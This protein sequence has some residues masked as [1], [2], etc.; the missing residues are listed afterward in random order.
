MPTYEF[1]PSCTC[2]PAPIHLMLA[3]AERDD[4]QVCPSC[5]A[6]YE[7]V[8]FPQDANQVVL[9]RRYHDPIRA[10]EVEA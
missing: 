4:P 1:K 7:R 2:H 5:G 9:P 3:I 10:S 6:P 8:L